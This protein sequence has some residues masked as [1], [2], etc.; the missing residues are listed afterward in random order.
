MVKRNDTQAILCE[1]L[2]RWEARSPLDDHFG[3]METLFT[4]DGTYTEAW[5]TNPNSGGISIKLSTQPDQSDVLFD[6][7]TPR[8]PI[9]STGI[10]STE[11]LTRSL[12]ETSKPSEPK[13][14]LNVHARSPST[15][16]PSRLRP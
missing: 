5:R 12:L 6:L 15:Q 10:S 14:P 7:S 8:P 13:I 2:E 9:P 11:V 16:L 1:Y 3:P 4:N